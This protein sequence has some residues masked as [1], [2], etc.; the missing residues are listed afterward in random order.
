MRI[1]LVLA[2]LALPAH[3]DDRIRP[4]LDVTEFKLEIHWVES[5]ADVF[6]ARAQYTPPGDARKEFR[7]RNDASEEGFAVL[8]RKGADLICR[9]FV[10]KPAFVNDKA[11]T[12]LGHEVEHCALGSYHP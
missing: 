5:E 1:L 8:V 3:A 11:T 12:A 7:Q 2:L 4:T 6:K 9:V 10:L